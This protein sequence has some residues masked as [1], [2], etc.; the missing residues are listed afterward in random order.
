MPH[1][2][3]PIGGRVKRRSGTIIAVTAGYSETPLPTKLG[4]RPSSRLLLV[5]APELPALEPLPAAT[6]VDR[7][8]IDGIYD[9]I[10]LFCA[11]L[12]HLHDGFE[13][14]V[15]SLTVPGA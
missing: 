8:E 14:L 7:D 6:I 4:I 5:N 3:A 15:T 2:I 10:L 13:S 11:N 12:D 9:V 1:T